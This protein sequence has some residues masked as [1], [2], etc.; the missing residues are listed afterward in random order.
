MPDNELIFLG[1][2]AGF[3]PSEGNT[4]ACIRCG[5][6]LLLIDCGE[7]VFGK[8][9]VSRLLQ[10][11]REMVVLISHLHSDHCGSLGSLL[12]YTRFAMG[13]TVR[14]VLPEQSEYA[15]DLRSMLRMNGVPDDAWIPVDG[16]AVWPFAGVTDI[17]WIPTRHAPGIPAFSFEIGTETGW[18]FYSADTCETGPVEDF[19]RR[20]PDFRHVYMDVCDTDR[21]GQVHVSLRQLCACI[22]PEQR[23][24]VS[25]MHLNVLTC[26]EAG[27]KEGF[28]VVSVY[29][30]ER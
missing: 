24:R 3:L 10:G 13:I 26:I 8:L 11:V 15:D 1:R 29:D 5:E 27:Q 20:V 2:G 14:I 17:R 22:R 9:L 28:D 19:L 21:P 16:V 25:L 18:I 23:S 12:L 7:T 6:R 30:T 4:S